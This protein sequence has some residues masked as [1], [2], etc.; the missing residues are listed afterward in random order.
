MLTNKA[1]IVSV[2]IICAA[3]IVFYASNST[4]KKE[5]TKLSD[6]VAPEHIREID[7]TKGPQTLKLISRDTRWYVTDNESLE[8]AAD[9]ARVLTV[10]DFIN[11]LNI[12]QKVTKKETSYPDFEV[13]GTA[14]THIVLRQDTGDSLSFYQGKTQDYSS[15]FIRE[16]GDPY[17]YLIS[18]SKSFSFDQ[19][20]WF[21][22]KAH[23]VGVWVN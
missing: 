5:K 4:N 16:E 2:I 11:N 14:A 12:I 23:R 7:I 10:F 20:M 19:D 22:K 18:E 15:C 8:I 1:T 13:A 6:F 9:S 21:Y 17:V 3:A